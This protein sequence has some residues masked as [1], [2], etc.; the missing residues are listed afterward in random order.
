MS[1][2]S[3]RA[4]LPSLH[5][6]FLLSP[7]AL[8]QQGQ[9]LFNGRNLD[10]WQ[11]R[12]D[13]VWTVL[14]NG[15]LLGQRLHRDP[16]GPMQAGPTI[17]RQQ[18]EAWLYRQAWLYTK[19]EYRE[20]DLHVEYWL[21]PGMNSGVSIRDVSRAHYAIGPAGESEPPLPG[22]LRGTPS[23]IGYEIQIIDSEEEKYPTGSIYL[24]AA[25]R[26]STQK[27]AAWNRLDIE[28]RDSGIKVR[29]NGDL[30]AEHPGAA[31]RPKSGPIGLQLH[32]QF[33]FMM[34]R[35]L[36]LREIGR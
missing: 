18:Y 19:T 14:E 13:G 33:T 30:V 7:A 9:A 35:N 36:H 25:A 17:D 22:N 8:C 3:P 27:T 31:G 6:L 32:D 15:V 28:S 24:F 34:F 4:L 20:F 29:V 1:S 11:V 10:G 23:H 21:P 26:R 16:A 5:L 2:A 12:G